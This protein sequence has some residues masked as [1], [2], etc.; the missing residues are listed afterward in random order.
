MICLLTITDIS[1][2][3]HWII[4]YTVTHSV[5]RDGNYTAT[6][7]VVHDGLRD[8]TKE[9]PPKCDPNELSYVR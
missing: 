8:H 3:A 1:L 4:N 2:P 9:R 5:M 6:Q 7:G